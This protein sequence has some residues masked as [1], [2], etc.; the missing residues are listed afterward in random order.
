M[1]Y[2]PSCGAKLNKGD[3]FCHE[4]G[5]PINDV[6]SH[7]SIRK[8]E[9]VGKFLSVQIVEVLLLNLQLYVRNADLKL[10]EEAPFL[11]SRNLKKS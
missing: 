9:Y 10:L 6:Q 11:Q 1:P 7:D 8:E 3:R 5:K 2:C 4:C